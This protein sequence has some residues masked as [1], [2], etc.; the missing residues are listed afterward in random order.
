MP[1]AKINWNSNSNGWAVW[2]IDETEQQ[3]AA[4][5]LP[6]DACPEGIQ[7]PRKRLEWLAG[8]VLLQHM[9][10]I[11]QLP[12]M[13]VVKDEFGKPYLNGLACQ[14]SVTNSFPYV[15]AQMHPNKPVG[16][17]LEQPRPKLLRVMK[18][19]LTP[20]EWQQAD[21]DLH[22]LCVYWCAKEALY[23]IYGKRSLIFAEH[24]IVR[25][26]AWAT[27]GNIEGLLR[28]ENTEQLLHLNYQRETDYVL[29][30]TNTAK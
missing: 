8:R 14:I 10:A 9:A 24:I 2:R 18:R 3:L 12:Y 6:V 25:P 26:F 21:N 29:V 7:F 13:G 17:D 20:D 22:K 4:Q 11:S 27:M 19:V 23:K 28:E 30:T 15:A 5:V 16:I 1:I